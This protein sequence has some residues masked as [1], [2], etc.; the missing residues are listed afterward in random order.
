[1]KYMIFD[2]DGVLLDSETGAFE[3]YRESLQLIGIDVTLE[4]LLHDYVGMTSPAIAKEIL[5]KYGSKKTVEEF[6][7]FHRSRGSYYEIS[8][9]VKPMEGLLDFLDMLKGN[10]VRMAMVSS[11]SSRNVLTAL[12]RMKILSYFD[13]VVC[14]DV[15]NNSKPNP[16][17]YLKAVE[18]LEAKKEE[19]VIVEDSAIGIQAGKNAGIYVVGYKGAAH[20]QDTS[21]ADMEV[22]SYSELKKNL[23]KC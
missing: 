21:E 20:I 7:A 3:M 10:G 5:E 16:E 19:C 17:G 12:N 9:E 18:Y 11:T 14:G 15:L 23:I 4:T 13:A 2:M 8:D 1:M 6:L 22:F